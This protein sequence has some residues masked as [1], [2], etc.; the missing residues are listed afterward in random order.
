MLRH[1]ELETLCILTL[2]LGILFQLIV[3]ILV[4]GIG[5]SCCGSLMSTTGA[6]G[7]VGVE[8]GTGGGGGPH[9]GGGMQGG[10]GGMHG[11]GGGIPEEEEG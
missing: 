4:L 11:G 5:V 8:G 1:E 7:G 6:G 2:L 3:F 10:G 9:G